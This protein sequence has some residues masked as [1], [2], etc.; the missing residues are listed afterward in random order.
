MQTLG[1]RHRL[2]QLVRA[3]TDRDKFREDNAR[4]RHWLDTNHKT[5]QRAALFAGLIGTVVLFVIGSVFPD[6]KATVLGLWGLL[7]LLVMGSIVVVEYINQNA[8]Y[9]AEVSDLPDD[10][11][12]RALA[13]EEI[14]I[15]S[16][17][18]LD[19]LEKQGQNA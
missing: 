17:A 18:R 13:Q 11:L 12:K 7:C 8:L 4:K 16:D 2:T 1:S 3:L 10:A 6:E 15:R 19:Q 5:A 14:A 9:G